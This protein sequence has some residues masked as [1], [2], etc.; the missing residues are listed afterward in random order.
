MLSRPCGL[1]FAQISGVMSL[2]MVLVSGCGT[3]TPSSLAKG[4]VSSNTPAGTNIS[5]GAQ[6]G[7]IWNAGDATL[8][9]L[10]GVPG[11]TQLGPALFPVGA[12]SAGAFAPLT[13][14][15]LLIDP[16]GN[17]QILILPSLV[18]ATVA[19]GISPSS[20]IAFAPR[21]GY[22]AV[23]APGSNSAVMV[24]GLP[25]APAVSSLSVTGGILGAAVS[26]AGTLLLATGAGSGG[27]AVTSISA[28]G[29]RTSLAS[30]AG[31]GGM[32]FIAGS[33]DSLI[34]DAAGNTL[35]RYHGGVATVLATHTNGLN[36]PFAVA[37]SQDGHWAVTVDQADGSLLR[38]DLT[39]A[40]PP[41][42]ST[43]ACTPTQL[44]A[45]SGNAVFE[46]AA[47]ASAP[48]W[49]IEAD[50]PTARVLFIPPVRSGQ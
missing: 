16:K 10:V 7:L 28:G 12:Y 21:G 8:R 35:A 20:V 32:S 44:S 19:Q 25:Q 42:Q 2:G 26:D 6:L 5:S 31:Y 18:P 47:P 9:T 22:A 11:S 43:C 45:L 4:P 38:V 33:E 14:T 13:Q 49:M 27:V 40:T 37:A 29:T 39:G 1:R 15:A 23:F 30:L 46:L 36:Q 48:G 34:A 3:G 24:T 50:S 41:A 17:L